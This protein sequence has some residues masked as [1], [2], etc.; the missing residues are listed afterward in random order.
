MIRIFAV[1]QLTVAPTFI[2]TLCDSSL[3]VSG[4]PNFSHLRNFTSQIKP[5]YSTCAHSL[6]GHLQSSACCHRHFRFESK[7]SL[8]SPLFSILY[9]SLPY[10]WEKLKFFR[11]QTQA[12]FNLV[13]TVFV[14]VYCLR[15][16]LAPVSFDLRP[17]PNIH[18]LSSSTETSNMWLKNRPPSFIHHFCIVYRSY[19]NS[20]ASFLFIIETLKL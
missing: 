6:P 20:D 7:Y 12:I 9:P 8:Y 15:L 11:L 17:S 1:A 4:L 19:D 16:M 5:F 3:Q 13:A 2:Q 10:F 14:P 18:I